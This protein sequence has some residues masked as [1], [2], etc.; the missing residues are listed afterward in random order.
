MKVSQKQIS[1]LSKNFV[2]Q[3]LVVFQGL[4]KPLQHRGADF[5]RRFQDMGHKYDRGINHGSLVYRKT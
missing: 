2:P 5:L 3:G 4:E 1:W